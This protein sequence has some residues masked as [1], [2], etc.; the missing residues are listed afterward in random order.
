MV[1]YVAFGLAV[2]E[3]KIEIMYLRTKEVPEAHA[4]FSVD[5]SGQEYN[6]TNEFIYLTGN[7]NHNA[8]LCLEVDRCICNARYSLRKYTLKLYDRPSALLKLKTRMLR[9]EVLEIIL[10]DCVT[11]SPRVYHYD[12]LRRSYYSFPTCF[13][14]RRKNNRI[15]HSIS[16]LDTLI[17]TGRKRIEV[18]IRRKRILFAELVVRMEGTRLPKCVM[19]GELVGGAGYVGGQEQE[20]MGCSLDDLRT[21]GVNANQ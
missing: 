1:V 17:E 13:I 18:T 6:Q 4:I 15:Y 7:V 12:T 16:Y 10:Y 8:G 14:G 9:A 3:V 5:T 19:F 11:W 21:F 20:W 2:S